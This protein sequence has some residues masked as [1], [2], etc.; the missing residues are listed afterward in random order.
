[1]R[2]FHYH[3]AVF[4]SHLKGKIG[5]ILDKDAVLRISLNID[6]TPIYSKSH[7]I[8]VLVF[9]H[10]DTHTQFFYFVLALSLRNKNQG[11]TIQVLVFHHSD[12]HTQFFYL[13]LALSLLNKNQGSRRRNICD[14]SHPRTTEIC[15]VPTVQYRTLETFQIS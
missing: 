4:S 11:N 15:T 1:M 5:N 7:T 14:R 12:T 2:Q 9:H 8:Q 6:D 13:V 3:R 10:P